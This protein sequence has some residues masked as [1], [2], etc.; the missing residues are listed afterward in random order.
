MKASKLVK[1]VRDR[2]TTA[3]SNESKR[4]PKL[5]YDTFKPPSAD[6]LTKMHYRDSNSKTGFFVFCK[7]MNGCSQLVA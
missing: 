5:T 3:R 1:Y 6:D 4:K 2:R 7:Q